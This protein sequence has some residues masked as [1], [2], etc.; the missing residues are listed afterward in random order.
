MKHNEQLLTQIDAFLLR[1]I[2]MERSLTITELAKKVRD[3]FGVDVDVQARL[4][5]Y[6][7]SDQNPL[8]YL[9]WN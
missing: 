4:K 5:E 2:E 3:K 7:P 6:C 8:A 1:A 9:Y